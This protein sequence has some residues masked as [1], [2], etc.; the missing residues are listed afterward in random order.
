[1]TTIY[2][3][4][5]E[6]LSELYPQDPDFATIW[7]ELKEGIATPPYSIRDDILYHQQAI[8]IARSLRRKVMDEAHAS[9]YAGHRGI[10]ASTNALERYFFWPTLRADI[11]K[12]IRECIVCQKVK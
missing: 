9:R 4:E 3:E 12:Y 5:L 8:H 6:S 1:M 7:K 10:V 11:E 2:H